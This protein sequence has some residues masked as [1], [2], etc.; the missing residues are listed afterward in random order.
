MDNV[1]WNGS[2]NVL[3]NCKYFKYHNCGVK[4]GAGVVCPDPISKYRFMFYAT[5]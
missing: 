3:W 2:E 5:V 4:E 1:N